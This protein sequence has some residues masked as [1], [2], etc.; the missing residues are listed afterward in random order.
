MRRIIVTRLVVL[1]PYPSPIRPKANNNGPSDIRPT[2][3]SRYPRPVTFLP[4][5]TAF[6][7]ATL[8]ERVTGGAG[9]PRRTINTFLL[10]A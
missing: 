10:E 3:A 8:E 6:E 4:A 1:S 9:V 2:S 7:I 5:M